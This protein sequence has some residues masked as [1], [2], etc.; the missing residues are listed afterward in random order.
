MEIGLY[1][2]ADMT[3]DPATGR[4]IS[5]EQ[6]YAEILAAADLADQAGIAVYA[7][8]EHHRLDIAISSPAI[9]M[10]AVAARTKRIRV[11]SAVT[12]LSTLDPV[13][14][15]EDFAT[16]DLISG[17][18]AEIIAGRG[19][20]LEF[21]PALRLQSRRLRRPLHREARPSPQA[22]RIRARHLAGPFPAAAR[23]RADFAASRATA[24]ADLDRDRRQCR[25]RCE[26]G[27]PRSAADARQ[28]HAA[29]GEPRAAGPRLPADRRRG[30]VRAGPHQGE[31]RRPHACRRDV[32]GR[33]GRI[34]PPLCALL[35]PP[36]AEAELRPRDPA[37]RV[38]EAGGRRTGRSSSAARRRS[39]TRCFG[40]ASCS[41]TSATWR[42]SISVAFRSARSL[43][44]SNSSKRRSCRRLPAEVARRFADRVASRRFESYMQ[45][46]KRA[47]GLHPRGTSCVPKSRMRSARSGRASP[48]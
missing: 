29:A 36:R 37:R 22:R 13:R 9:V 41:A 40:S 48:C 24:A 19:T 31:P 43:A 5:V 12:I 34:L 28:Y 42:R 30:G 33:A 26:R 38:R 46:R 25:E 16:V 6:R 1:T 2:F 44:P 20:F 10:A 45:P 8:G 32:A 21:V 27:A 7:F 39:S 18:R 47:R 14:V 3:P 35:P 17:G 15:F 4:M 11:A 23:R